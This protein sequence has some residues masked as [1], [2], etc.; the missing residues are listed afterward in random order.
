MPVALPTA[1]Y[2]HLGLHKILQVLGALY[3]TIVLTLGLVW[4]RR[5]ALGLGGERRSVGGRA[6]GDRRGA[7]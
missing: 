6:A 3:V 1:F 5:A 2:G 7:V 4:R